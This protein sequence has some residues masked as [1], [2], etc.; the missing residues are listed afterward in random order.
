[1]LRHIALTLLTCLTLACPGGPAPDAGVTAPVVTSVSP[2]EGPSVGGTVVSVNGAHFQPGAT[3]SF[4]DATALDVAVESST[5]LTATSPAAAAPGIVSVRVRNPDGTEGIL[6]GAFRYRAAASL[7]VQEAVLSNPAMTTDSSGAATVRVDVSAAV[8]VPGV[9]PGAGQGG[10]VRAQVGFATTLSTPPA[11]SDFTWL[12]ASY[13][14]DADGATAGA[15]A[16]D[17]YSASVTVPGAT[18]AEV[19]YVLGARFSVNGGETWALADRDGAA[20][21]VTA[22]QLAQLIVTRAPVDWCKLGGQAVEA[23]P[24]VSL[25]VGQAGP[26]IYGQV[27]ARGATDS[28]GRGAGIRGQLGVGAPGAPPEGWSWSDATFNVDTGGGANDEY[29]ATLPMLGVGNARF[30][31]RFSR[32][33]GPWVYCDAD[34]LAVGGFSEAQAGSV[35][36]RAPVIDDC[37]LQF[38]ASLETRAGRPSSLVYG[39]VFAAGITDAP[40]QGPGVEAQLGF[41]P[42]GAMA[43]D[44]SWAWSSMTSFNVDVLGGDEYAGTFTGPA[45]GA[46]A[47]AYRVRVGGGPWVY[48][49]RDGSANGYQ[50]AQA[51]VLT[52]RPDSVDCRLQ[53]VSTFA[54]TSGAPVAVAVRVLGAPL[55]GGAPQPRVQVGVGTQGDNASL[56][57]AWGWQD[58]PVSGV[59]GGELE[60]GRTI[61]PAYTGTRAVAARA[62]VDDGGTWTYC[63][64]N[65]SDVNGYE[66]SQQY[67]VVV[68]PHAD[69]DFC[70]LQFPAT[71][72]G[73]VAIYGQ[74]YEPGLT[75]SASA[76][77]TA[78]LGLGQAA[79]DPGLAYQWLPAPFFGLAGNNNEHRATLPTS[80][81]AD[82]RFVFRFTRDGGSFCYGDLDGSQ[83]GFSGGPNIGRVVP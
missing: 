69:F 36:V 53:S 75:P 34:G 33:D 1:M 11:V 78:W 40:G 17:L 3:V 25:L 64:L 46:W 29:Q 9:T 24:A 79:E 13:A 49:D 7:R 67:D 10:G 68:G 63:D 38:P 30:A 37:A 73:G 76:D 16:R 15:K 12:D 41:G 28:V 83:N 72:D 22:A 39:R 82:E 6:P 43:S 23:P 2:D 50:P 19:T 81:R 35:T 52:A 20:N 5:R 44:A 55:D 8:E 74:V 14:G 48:C 57:A 27:Y 26:L 31:F 54:T 21:G 51:G 62:S 77:I 61:F 4:G 18:S 47:Y 45:P 70:N 80:A 59:A 42:V 65:G 56:S 32:D 66:V 60:Y 71:A 58:S